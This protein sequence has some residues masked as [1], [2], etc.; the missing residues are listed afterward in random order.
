MCWGEKDV[1]LSGCFVNVTAAE[2]TKPLGFACY[3]TRR[4]EGLAN[5]TADTNPPLPKLLTFCNAQGSHWSSVSWHIHGTD[6]H[7]GAM[8]PTFCAVGLNQFLCVQDHPN[9]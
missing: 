7:V 8:K 6:L 1:F 5:L 2:A 4:H 9:P 3:F